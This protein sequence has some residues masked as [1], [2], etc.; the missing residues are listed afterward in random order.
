[1]LTNLLGSGTSSPDVRTASLS[2]PWRI[3]E[4]VEA[5]RIEGSGDFPVAYVYF[6]DDEGRRASM[7]ERTAKEDARRIAVNI[8]RLPELEQ[9]SG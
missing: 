9:A 4:L 8:A 2:D 7:P 6:C 5:F 3:V 1:M